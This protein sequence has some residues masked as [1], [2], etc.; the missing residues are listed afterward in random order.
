MYL[1]DGELLKI[2]DWYNKRCENI[3]SIN[4]LG[5]K[6]DLMYQYSA[7]ET[8]L[9]MSTSIGFGLELRCEQGCYHLCNCQGI[10][11]TWIDKDFDKI[12]KP[13]GI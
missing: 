10:L 1:T 5:T 6:S 12:Q 7:N 13:R 4:P 2:V 9:V 3:T 11:K 8:S